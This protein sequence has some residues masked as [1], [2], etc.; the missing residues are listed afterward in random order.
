M[1]A[2]KCCAASLPATHRKHLRRIARNSESKRDKESKMGSMRGTK[3]E[4]G[5]EVGREKGV[6]LCMRV[7][8]SG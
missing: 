6:C 3:R 1:I 5:R 8:V 7:S 2:A 4:R